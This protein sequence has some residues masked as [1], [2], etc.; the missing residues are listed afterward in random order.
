MR[1]RAG[2][3]RTRRRGHV[4][5]LQGIRVERRHVRPPA[6]HRDPAR[7]VQQRAAAGRV[8]Q[9]H[10]VIHRGRRRGVRGIGDIHDFQR[11]ARHLREPVPHQVQLR[12]VRVVARHVHPPRAAHRQRVR[13]HQARLGRIAYVHHRERVARI[14]RHVGV[15]P[16]NEHAHRIV[17]RQLAGVRRRT[18]VRDVHDLQR[19]RAAAG[20]HVRMIAPHEHARCVAQLRAAV[21]VG[22]LAGV[23]RRAR[24]R[25]VD[26]LQRARLRGG[27]VRMRALHEH[28]QGAVQRRGAADRMRQPPGV[29]RVGRV[30][31]RV[32]RV[33][34]RRR[35]GVHR[36]AHRTGVRRGGAVA[37]P[38]TDEIRPVGREIAELQTRRGRRTVRACGG[39]AGARIARGLDV[40]ERDAGKIIQIV[41]LQPDPH[42]PRL[43]AGSA[44]GRREV[45]VGEQR[46]ASG[47]VVQRQRHA[48]ARGTLPGDAT[49]PAL[50]HVHRHRAVPAQFAFGRRRHG[51]RVRRTRRTARRRCPRPRRT[52][53][54][55]CGVAARCASAARYAAGTAGCVRRQHLHQ[56]RAQRRQAPRVGG[57]HQQRMPPRARLHR[58]RERQPQ[59]RLDRG[60]CR[61]VRFGGPHG[62]L[63]SACARRPF[64]VHLRWLGPSQRICVRVGRLYDQRRALAGADLQHLAG[65]IPQQC[66]LTV[67][68]RGQRV[69]R[70]REHRPY[71]PAQRA[72]NRRRAAEPNCLATAHRALRI[73][74]GKTREQ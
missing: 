40:T 58:W 62:R 32:G 28:R 5:H 21:P 60:P 54:A 17:Q 69:R 15:I 56:Q 59:P 47:G 71:R 31:Q 48:P 26:H 50:H 25:D 65:H 67:R 11:A 63:V 12:H 64:G 43:A 68:R 41:D 66:R 6:P 2:G 10:V 44:L 13:R 9:V 23:R 53:L 19:A 73:S 3:P 18:R 49:R 34:Q 8:A 38:Q 24:I 74:K 1:Q 27:H 46:P 57:A 37:G 72:P 42:H 39:R 61:P 45:T 16:E 70:P 22:Q 20:G 4:Q 29:T 30:G 52:G 35:R 55:R 7:T 36:E 33:A 14:Q 51:P